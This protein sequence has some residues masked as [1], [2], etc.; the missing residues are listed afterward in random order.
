MLHL[1]RIIHIVLGAFWFGAIIFMHAF[2]MPTIRALGPAGGPV[3]GHLGQSR[4]LPQWLISAGGLTILSGAFLYWRDSGGLQTSWVT[5]PMG[6]TLGLG[7][8]CALVAFLIGVTVNAPGAKR[9]GAIM[10]ARGQAGGPPS[11]EQVAEIAQLQA[12]MAKGQLAAV[13]LLTL[14]TM[15]MA[16]ARYTT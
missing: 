10:A 16:V 9:L 13:I 11:P 3:M 1:L 14:A 8:I 15:A 5:T 7:A 4:K 12:R 2:L 6:M